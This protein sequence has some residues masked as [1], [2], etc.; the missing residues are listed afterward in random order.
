MEDDIMIR[1]ITIGASI[2]ITLATVTVIM[3]YY[4]TAKSMVA[5]V[6]TGIDIEQQYREDIKKILYSSEATGAELRNV[7]QYF[8]DSID[9]TITIDNYYAYRI[10]AS[11]NLITPGIAKINSSEN[12]VYIPIMKTI[13]PNQKFRIIRNGNNYAFQLIS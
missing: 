10:D 6:G 8:Y 12:V 9:V 3:M 2:L 11:L 5:E 1:S 7:L 13:M 4:N